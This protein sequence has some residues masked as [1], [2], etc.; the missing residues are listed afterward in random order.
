M[1]LN[2]TKKQLSNKNKQK[3]DTSEDEDTN[4]SEIEF[5][6]N[7][8]GLG[9]NCDNET[10]ATKNISALLKRLETLEKLQIAHNKEVK[11]QKTDANSD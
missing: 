11:N 9:F 10:F 4:Q 5:E 6:M 7:E 2:K 8:S 3:A 1:C